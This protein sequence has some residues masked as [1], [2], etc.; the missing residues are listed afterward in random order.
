LP[1]A[2]KQVATTN[3]MHQRESKWA[4]KTNNRLKL[5]TST[6]KPIKSRLI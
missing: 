6:H 5:F 4:R 3:T 2:N 1:T